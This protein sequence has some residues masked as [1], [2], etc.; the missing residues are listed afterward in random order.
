MNKVCL[1]FSIG[2]LLPSVAVC[3]TLEEKIAT[4]I[5]TELSELDLKEETAILNQKA[6]AAMQKVYQ[7]YQPK[8]TKLVEDYRKKYPQ[9]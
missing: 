7:D 5:C 9:K 4:T 3:Q 1:I 2:V 6:I 8:A